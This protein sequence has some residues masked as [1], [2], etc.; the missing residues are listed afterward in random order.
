MNKAITE[1]LALMP[2]AF[3]EGLDLWSRED[4]EPGQGSWAAQPNAA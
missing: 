2:P 3:S 1:G 4:G